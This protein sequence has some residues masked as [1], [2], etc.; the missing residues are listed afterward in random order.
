MVVH[1]FFLDKKKSTKFRKS[2]IVRH[3]STSDVANELS[4]KLFGGSSVDHHTTLTAW[5]VLAVL[6][7]LPSRKQKR[8]RCAVARC[9]SPVPS[10]AL[11]C[12]DVTAVLNEWIEMQC[13][14]LSC[15]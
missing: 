15:A 5:A 10:A 9:A 11:Q 7:L 1:P 3:S 14:C 8:E 2:D 13:V 4:I 6:L 12:D